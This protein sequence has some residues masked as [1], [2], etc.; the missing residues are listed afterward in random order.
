MSASDRWAPLTGGPTIWVVMAVEVMTF[1]LFLIAFAAQWGDQPIVYRASQLQLHPES[2][3]VGTGWL[4]TGSWT[5]YRA[6][7]A[8]ERGQRA[9]SA[10]WL[11]A[12]GWLGALF[13]VHKL[14]DYSHLEG[15]GLSTNS[16]WFTY[17]FLTGLHLL[18]VM[19]G[20]V[21]FLWL[22]RQL[23]G[24]GLGDD[25]LLHTQ[26]AAVYWHLVDVV[27]LL[28]FPILYLMHP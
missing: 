13:S 4:L 7:L 25:E 21:V 15:V 20:A 16:F 27:W 2:A 9:T 5:A 22:G 18:H 10:R 8:L 19:V 3:L 23:V 12:T 11:Q 6:V 26:S 17:L 14:W 24:P 28:L 1:G